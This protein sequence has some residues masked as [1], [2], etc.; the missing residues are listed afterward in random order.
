[1]TPL[2]KLITS[3]TLTTL[4]LCIIC[5]SCTSGADA[6]HAYYIIFDPANESICE[7]SRVKKARLYEKEMDEFGQI[8][9]TICYLE[10]FHFHPVFHDSTQITAS[11][12]VSLPLKS[13]QE[14]RH[15][16]EKGRFLAEDGSSLNID[17][18]LIID[19]LDVFLVELNDKGGALKYE[20]NWSFLQPIICGDGSEMMD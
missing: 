20:V 2:H 14:L 15:E 7:E 13:A 5:A 17:S 11:E 9:F 3:L 6:R 1:M 18:L 10:R 12:L 19:K 8:H 16:S 4:G